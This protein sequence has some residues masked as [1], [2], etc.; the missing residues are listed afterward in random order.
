M[1]KKN[2]DKKDIKKKDRK[3]IKKNLLKALAI[4]VV[5]SVVF[6][7]VASIV[8]VIVAK[9]GL[10]LALSFDKV[11]YDNQLMPEKDADGV[12]TFTTDSDLRIM[13]LTDVHIGGGWMSSDK[14]SKALNAVAAMITA[15]KPDLVIVTGDI[16][17]PVPIQSGTFDNMKSAEIFASLMEKLGVYWLPIFGNH[18]TESYSKYTRKEI[19]DFYCDDKWTYC[20]FEDNS[21]DQVD[22]YSN[23]VVNVKNSKGLIVQS[24]YAF[25]SHSYIDGDYFGL[26]WKYDNIHSN[27]IE[28]YKKNVEKYSNYN[29][30]LIENS[31]SVNASYLKTVFGTP[32]SLAFM[33]IPTTEYLDAWNAYVSAGYKDIPGIKYYYGTVGETGKLVYHGVYPDQLVETMVALKSTQGIFCGHDHLNNF[34]ISYQGISL[35][36]GLSVDYLAYKGI[37]KLG[38]QRGCTM[39]T[40]FPNG[41]FD[42]VAENYY[43]DKYQT[44]NAYQKETVEMQDLNKEH[45]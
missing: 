34:S 33:H 3:K 41:T 44:L 16:V 21:N 43:Q 12:W 36:Y 2:N 17:Y 4:I 22:G 1:S 9:A 28:W 30:Q 40:V 35:T 15:E 42:C 24:L 29:T 27:Q 7:I 32:R 31:Y 10:E 8:N 37:S 23:Q 6:A 19:S 20:I 45:E 13:Q 26:F 39:I 11:Q 14:D 18:D 38:S 25:D 5:F